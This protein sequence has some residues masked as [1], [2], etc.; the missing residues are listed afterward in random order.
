VQ[1]YR[2][3]FRGTDGHFVDAAPFEC[4]DDQQA[5]VI[6]REK[7]NGRPAELWQQARMVMDFPVQ[8]RAHAG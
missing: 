4:G 6:A 8:P 7:A 1:S 3:F 2:L 5:I